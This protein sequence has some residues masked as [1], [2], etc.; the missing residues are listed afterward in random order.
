MKR[1]WNSRSED[2]IHQ[3][4]DPCNVPRQLSHDKETMP[5][6]VVIEP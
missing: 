3:E 2:Q 6:A 5:R 1:E 4:N